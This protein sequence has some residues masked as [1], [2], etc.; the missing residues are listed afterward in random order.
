[1]SIIITVE[2]ILIVDDNINNIRLLDNLLKEKG[3][4]VAIAQNGIDA[5]EICSKI[6]PD[7][8]LLD[9]MMEGI[10]GYETCRKLKEI[11]E[12]K[13]IPVI[14][15][16]S[17]TQTENK[18]EGF[19]AGGIDYLTKPIDTD[20]LYIRVETHISINRMKKQLEAD[21][22]EKDKLLK[23]NIEKTEELIKTQKEL[24]NAEKISSLGF[25]VT[26]MAHELNTPLSI[27]VTSNS[28]ISEKYN[29][30]K[31]TE[32]DLSPKGKRSLE[33]IKECSNLISGNLLKLTSII[34]EF[35][36]LSIHHIATNKKDFNVKDI[37][38]KSSTIVKNILNR[39]DIE[40]NIKGNDYHFENS[41]PEALEKVFNT[42]IENSIKHA[43]KKI[44]KPI[45][46]IILTSKEDTVQID[47]KDNGIGITPSILNKIFDPFFTTSR[48]SGTG[49]G[50][51]V[52]YNIVTQQ[53]A[54]TIYYMEDHTGA[55]FRIL[56]PKT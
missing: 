18:V 7:L 37:I 36:D 26:G 49:L 11:K 5:I 41:Y 6:V 12:I 23:E 29:S 51:S 25:L 21:L 15:L 38:T 45:I 10:D 8:I 20:E 34:K 52:A 50:L 40:I 2:T 17:L 13:N 56:I 53:L 4:R 16:S 19:N 43:F 30:I 9:I 47:L 44:D 14:F 1:M 3:Y 48:S 33:E 54:G 42:L 27:C 35:K 39:T 46:D 31:I 22:I 28:I 24:F 32:E 55:H